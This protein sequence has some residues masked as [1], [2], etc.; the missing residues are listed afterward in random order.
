V[1]L[2]GARARAPQSAT[3]FVSLYHAS[4]GYHRTNYP[5]KGTRSPPPSPAS[6][7]CPPSPFP[8]PPSNPYNWPW[9]LLSS[10]PAFSKW[11]QRGRPATRRLAATERS[12]GKRR[13]V[14]DH[15]QRRRSRRF[16]C[17]GITPVCQTTV[18]TS[19]S[20]SSAGVTH[21]A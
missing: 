10:C 15:P 16:P 11:D 1:A 19:S 14:T 3:V 4:A 21:T 5:F 18:P 2:A 13:D 6:P 12:F 20:I 17:R 7:P 9:N 8:P